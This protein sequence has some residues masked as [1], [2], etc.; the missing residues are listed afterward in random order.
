MHSAFRG[1]SNMTYNA[2]DMPDFSR[3]TDM[4]RMFDGASSFDGDLSAWDVSNVNDMSYNVQGRPIIQ[5]RYL[6]M[7]CLERQRHVRDVLARLLL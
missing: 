4:E 2:D 3:V 1:A 7:G 5:L 6:R